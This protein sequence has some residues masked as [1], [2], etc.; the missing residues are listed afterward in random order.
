MSLLQSDKILDQIS[1]LK[2]YG[3]VQLYSVKSNRPKDILWQIGFLLSLHLYLIVE[4]LTDDRIQKDVQ[5]NVKAL[6]V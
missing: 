3:W 1:N 2:R 5:L 4:H 6:F